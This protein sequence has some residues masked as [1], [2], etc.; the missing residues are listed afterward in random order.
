MGL[1]RLGRGSSAFESDP[2]DLRRAAVALAFALLA[3]SALDL[4]VT[5]VNIN[6]LGAVEINPLIAPLIGTPWVAVVKIGIPVGILAMSPWA[7]STRMLGQLRVAVAIYLTVAI[8]GVGQ[9][10]YAIS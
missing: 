9:L 7:R 8:V 5:N 2:S 6:N 3:L 1:G 4:A 10:A